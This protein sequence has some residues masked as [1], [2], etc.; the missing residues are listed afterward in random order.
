VRRLR[1][2]DAQQRRT[3]APLFGCGV[4]AVLAV[5]IGANVLGPLGLGQL[6]VAVQLAAIAAVPIGFLVVVL[7]GG[8]A[9]TGEL[10]AFVGSVASSPGSRHDLEQ[11][12]A[13]TLGDPSAALLHWEA[14]GSCYV[15]TAREVVPLPDGGH[16]AAVEVAVADRR[17]GAIVYDPRLIADPAVVGAVGRVAGIALDRERLA[18]EVSDSRRALRDASS[19]LL[20]DSDRQRRR[21][22]RDLHD[23]L[24]VS[25]VR[26]SMQAHQLA[27]HPSGEGTQGL[28]ARLAA[29]V[30]DAAAALRALVHGVM[31]APLVERGLLAAVQDLAYGLPVRTRLDAD[32]APLRLSAPV[33]STAYFV[34]AE[35]LTNV[36][37]HADARNVVV[38]LR[39]HDGILAIEV[40]D[41]G[42]GGVAAD[43]SRSGLSGLS[44]LRDRLEVFGGTLSVSSGTAGTE[45]RAVLPCG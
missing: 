13:T 45:L 40:T 14:E 9:R 38:S 34:V 2:Y 19:R 24:Q 4:L 29:D 18:R 44:G 12:V 7:R 39:R 35:A 5:A 17:L 6:A 25:L 43:D 27:A 8:F 28:A 37:K 21:I 33:E 42:H 26:L 1:E 30:D 23:G 11:A 41:D 22:A 32:D 31:P 36:I 3:L 15:D 10:G 16:R 20:D